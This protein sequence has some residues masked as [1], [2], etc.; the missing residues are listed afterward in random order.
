[1][2]RA[3]AAYLLSISR[4]GCGRERRKP[5]GS[6]SALEISPSRGRIGK[7]R[8][9]S[10]L[11]PLLEGRGSMS[12]AFFCFCGCHIGVLNTRIKDAAAVV[13]IRGD[14]RLFDSKFLPRNSRFGFG[15]QKA[16]PC[17]IKRDKDKGSLLQV[18]YCGIAWARFTPFGVPQPGCRVIAWKPLTQVT[19]CLSCDHCHRIARRCSLSMPTVPVPLD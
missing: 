9:R 18:T 12:A 5:S 8:A 10:A 16:P 13:G 1:M 14:E 6:R 11:E 4:S 19:S 17:H 15:S 2:A 7:T 3:S